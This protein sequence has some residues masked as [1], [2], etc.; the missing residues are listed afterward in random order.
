MNEM[1]GIERRPVGM[2][3]RLLPGTGL[4][5]ANVIAEGT[6]RAANAGGGFSA[7]HH[8]ANDPL[9]PAGV[10]GHSLP[11]GHLTPEEDPDGFLASRDA[12]LTR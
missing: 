7:E 4:L 5:A 1:D 9:P 6:A 2:S 12:F 10:S 8:V 3:R 11:C